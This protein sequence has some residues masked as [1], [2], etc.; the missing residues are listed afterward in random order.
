VFITGATASTYTVSSADVGSTIDVVVSATNTGGGTDAAAAA[1]ATV[2]AAPAGGSG[3]SSGGGSSGGSSG[4]GG[5]TG[6]SLD[7]ALS[8]YQT[9]AHAV[10]GMNVTYVLTATMLTQHQLAQNVNVAVSLPAG[11]SYVGSSVDRGSGCRPSTSASLVCNLDFLS[12]QAMTGTVVIS[13]KVI[14]D[15]THT[16]VA[17]V[18]TQQSESSLTNNTVTITDSS[19][20]TPP[21]AGLNGGS[22]TSADTVKPTAHALAS[23]GTRGRSAKLRFKIYDDR[24][25][26]KALAMVRHHGRI[27]KTLK[28][29]FG[30]VAYGTVYYVDWKVP[31]NAATGSYVF[32][33]TAVDKASNRSAPSCAPLTIR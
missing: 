4:G 12:D 27:V 17:T 19:G 14:S 29:G 11:V 31:T 18:S 21:P 13:A 7:L 16:L 28:T 25:V 23:A 1:T 24:G 5:G 20:T 30:P 15:G 3:G 9:P 6:G 2:A 22:S 26:A 33:V 8:G 32:C 10:A